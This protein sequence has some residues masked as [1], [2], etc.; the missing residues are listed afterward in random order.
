[1]TFVVLLLA[2]L[3]SPRQ[4]PQL[5]FERAELS[6]EFFSEGAAAADFDRDGHVD[7]ASGPW[8]YRGPD[9]QNH[10]ELYPPTPFDPAGYSD[11]FFAWPVDVDADGWKDILF[12]G[13]PGTKAEWL[14]NPGKT[15]QLW[16][17]HLVLDVV[18]DESPQFVDIDAD[19]KRDLVCAKDGRLGWASAN[20]ADPRA[21]WIWHIATPDMGFQRFTHG[22]GIGDI[23][24][25][26]RLDLIEHTGWWRQPAQLGPLWQRHEHMFGDRQGGAQMYAY[27]VD[28]DG[29]NDVI[30]SLAAHGF[31]LSWFEQ[32]PSSSGARFLEHRIMD[33]DPNG[34]CFAELHAVLLV[35]VDRDGLMDIVT[36]KRWWSHGSQGDPQP[37][38]PAVVAWFR[39]TRDD[40]GANYT[41]YLADDNSGVGT[42]LSSADVDQDGMADFV[43]GNKRG[44]FVLFQRSGAPQ[45]QVKPPDKE[46]DKRAENN[47]DFESGDLSHWTVEGDAFQ[48]QP[49][50]GDAVARRGRETSHHAGEFWI[51]GYEKVGDEAKGSLTSD[52]FL[53]KQPFASFLV[54]GGTGSGERVEFWVEGAPKPF[55]TTS[56]ANYETMQ[57]IVV[58][59]GA[60]QDRQIRVRIVDDESGGWG[61][62]N[63]DDLRLHA[64]EPKF[65]RPSGTPPV[66][67]LDP[68]KIE[69]Q[70]AADAA[71]A[72]RV[73]AGFSVD[74]IAAE[75]DL[76][77]PI[78]LTIDARG[79]LW[80]AE[81]F[82]YPT[83]AK[84]GEG[85]DDILVFEDV[86]GDGKFEKRTVF[87]SGL[88]LISGL[89]VGHGGVWIGAA[90]YFQFIPDSNDDL[91]PDG[92]AQTLLDGWGYEDTHETL[93]AFTWGPDG[94][95]YGC[96]GVFTHSRVGKP[97]TKDGDRTPLNAGIWRFHPTRREFEV[98]AWGTSNP[99]GVDFNDRGQAFETAC[100]IPHLYH[101]IQGARYERQ[102]GE[103]FGDYV[104]DDIKTIADHRHYLG[105]TP[106]SGNLRSD[107]AGGGHAHCGALIYLGDKFP[108]KYRDTILFEN[109]HGNR[110]N[111]DLLVAEGSGFVG[112]H[113]DDF[114]LANDAWF[115]GIN[116]KLGPDGAVY[117]IDWYDKQ[118]C[119]LT[120]PQVWDRT[121]G[122]MYRVRCGDLAP[123]TVNL[124]ALDS[125]QLVELQASANEFE[126]RRARTVLAQ[127]GSDAKVH[128]ALITH[129]RSET[130]NEPRALRWLWALHVTSGLS[131]EVASEM[132]ASPLAYVQAWTI[133]LVCERGKPSAGLMGKIADLARTSASPVVRLY[134]SSALQRL[135]LADRLPIAASL[136]AHAEDA[137]DHNLPLMYWYAVEP[138]LLADPARSI[139][140]ASASKIPTVSRFVYRRLA[141][142]PAQHELLVSN[143]A[144]SK[145]SAQR[146]MLLEEL[147]RS[148]A[149]H[150]DARAPQSWS[151]VAA[152][153][154]AS[155]D[156]RVREL[157]QNIAVSYGDEKSLEL[158]RAVLSDRKRTVLERMRAIDVVARAHD[159]Q[160]IETLLGF[161]DERPLR[162][163]TLGALAVFDEER[164]GETIAR[165]I[166]SFDLEERR[167]AVN[168]LAERKAWA[169]AL[170]ASLDK[171]ELDK[172]CLDAIVA[173]K[174]ANLGDTAVDAGLAKHFGRAAATPEDKRV[175]IAALKSRL[176]SE[177]LSKADLPHGRELFSRTCQ[178]CHSLF[179]SGAAVG[180]DITGSNRADLDY[181]LTNIVD[182][183]ALV[184]KEYQVTMIWLEDERLH[185]GILK[186]QNA[187]SVTLVDQ[188]GSTVIPRADIAEMK[189][190]TQSMMPE[191][192]IDAMSPDEIRDLVAYVSSPRQTPIR[193]TADSARKIFDGVSLAGWKGDSA[194]WSVEDGV[195]TG[196]TDGLAKNNFLVSELEC[197]D[198]R[199]V[200]EI[201]LEK[202][203]GNSG[204]QFR[205][206]ALD[207]GE[208]RGY[209]ADVGPGWWGALYEEE[210]RALL[211]PAA[212]TDGRVVQSGWNTYE[213]VA[214]GQHVL[215]AING[216]KC[217]DL[218]DPN[219]ALRGVFALQVHSGGATRVHVRNLHLE[220][221]PKLELT[222]SGAAR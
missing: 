28:G 143:L 18:D 210:G 59:L 165:R 211:S 90:P 149:V 115:R 43:I 156:A 131:D 128:A 29:D 121:N 184:A 48:G 144:T 145:D 170:F 130:K 207:S 172:S 42:Q 200:L 109:I 87:V 178:Q 209:Q 155:P 216:R 101:M 147:E 183:S 26:G 118:A 157:A 151:K 67:A 138:A 96:H 117:F 38:S 14:H 51:G 220:L 68:P 214:V 139:E 148:L 173:R 25:D 158:V 215:T 12:V 205:S 99:W 181:L 103:H 198:F 105:E 113:G 34:I 74:V 88:N 177:V 122:R 39:L 112:K 107:S 102:G 108:A 187:D 17:R 125:M 161:L 73:P 120:D 133:Q 72:M 197:G 213:I 142:L 98:F 84:E 221:D 58:P 159:A 9:F 106:H 179:G 64:Q 89:E 36:G 116:F 196:Q 30:T 75:P 35:D 27:D 13:F 180:P 203:A 140:L 132:L 5:H 167:A 171:G 80:V 110:V 168:T 45:L 92:P 93:N 190:A 94:W 32:Q 119:H 135:P 21:P 37:G 218:E 217:V 60:N 219:G 111:N 1:M 16:T 124:A 79:R 19:G 10:I 22:L 61:H 50:R 222:T 201:Q 41:P 202:D 78:A 95:L 114:L 123:K 164:I 46:P 56:G 206:Q 91:V 71:K 2:T 166:S 154:G 3:P 70:S 81:A 188:Q 7:V 52:W 146:L 212:P 77:Q 129:L 163:K 175:K 191:G 49:I 44:T 31:G 204:I 153:L 15:D 160:S 82:T 141:E 185:S 11:N 194:I 97:G 134:V 47:L 174:L 182:P 127:R 85:K 8:L 62:I 169:R 57:R 195:L 76:H 4:I 63:F 54:G 176:T 66:L 23:D 150:R 193:A 199:M 189:L 104:Y 40:N 53:A 136:V 83:R 126:V 100:V 20:P 186:T 152:Q 208:M 24:G 65:E 162:V 86:D 192:Q 137:K 6:H 69:G 55:F 33:D